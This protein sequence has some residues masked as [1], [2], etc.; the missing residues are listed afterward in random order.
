MCLPASLSILK[1]LNYDPF[2]LRGYREQLTNIP[3]G[4][5]HAVTLENRAAGGC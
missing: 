4:G 1:V 3:P 5:A 2:Y